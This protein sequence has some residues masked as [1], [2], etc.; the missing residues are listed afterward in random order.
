[1]NSDLNVVCKICRRQLSKYTCP[2]CNMPYCS[3][4]CFRSPSHSECSESFYKKEI[5]SGIQS[6][7]SK[8]AAE[9][10]KMMELL[11]RFEED[12]AGSEDL[13]LEEEVDEVSDIAKKF[14][15]VDLDSTS[16]DA[17]WSILS[18]DERTKFISLL[19]NPS[20]E[21][22]QSLLASEELDNARRDPW[23][24]DGEDKQKPEMMDIPSTSPKAGPPLVYNICAIF[25][26]YVY[27]TRHLAASPLDSIPS[28]DADYLEAR[29]LFSQL[30]PFLTEKKA[31]TLH[32]SLTSV[33]T[34]IWS[35]FDPGTMTAE[36]FSLLLRDVS[37]LLTP[38]TVTEIAPGQVAAYQHLENPLLVISD[39]HALFNSR[40]NHVSHK[41]LFYAV[42]VRSISTIVFRALAD[43][44][45]ARSLAVAEEKDL[46]IPESIA[47]SIPRT[48]LPLVEEL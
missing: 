30:V 36:T 8:S 25:L 32:T 34:D 2:H 29:R 20:S 33:I 37:R 15:T 31:T 26:A 3:L 7:P 12:T 21:L 14:Q 35:R 19:N 22:V 5:Q 9:R 43:E 23:W 4:S 10:L 6:E 40:Q 27:V 28:Q 44:V 46:P 47:E 16:A 38:A 41:L 42:H 17:M 48:G 18:D 24:E 1:M 45:A 13:I 11:K 39:L